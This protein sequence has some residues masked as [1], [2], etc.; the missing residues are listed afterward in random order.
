MILLSG[1]IFRSS[2]VTLGKQMVVYQSEVAVLC[3]LTGIAQY[4]PLLTQPF[5]SS[6]TGGVSNGKLI[7]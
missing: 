3:S 5:C 1:S 7:F 2:V 6:A 4:D